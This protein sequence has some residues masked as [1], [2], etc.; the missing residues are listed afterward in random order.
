MST[1]LLLGVAGAAIGFFTGGVGFIGLGFLAGS[2]IGSLI[3]PQKVEGPRLGDLKLQVSTYGKM[4]PYV[5]GT[6]RIAGNVI[7]QTDLE[8]H[9]QKS[10]GKGGPE[11]ISYTYSASFDL[12]LCVGPILGIKRIWADARLIW[13]DD[14]G[15]PIPCTVYLGSASQTPDPTFE[16]IHGVGNV[17]GY[18]GF[19][20]VVFSDYF[21]TDFGNRIPQFEFEIF[22]NVG[23]FPWRVSEF[24]PQPDGAGARA[25]TYANGIVTVGVYKTASLPN[26]HYYERQFNLD[27]T[28]VAG[29]AFDAEVDLPGFP[30]GTVDGLLAATDGGGWYQREALVATI[31]VNPFGPA[32]V[33]T[34]VA[35]QTRVYNN[36]FIFATGS[37][38]LSGNVGLARWPCP[39]GVITAAT[40]TA[41]SF[42][43]LGTV[44]LSSWVVGKTNRS[45][46]CYVFDAGTITLFEYSFDLSTLIRQ[47]D[48]TAVNTTSPV[49]NGALFTVYQ[50][51]N[52]DLILA[53]DRGISGG[54]NAAAFYLNSD[55]TVS[56]IGN[57]TPGAGL[58][59]ADVSE[60]GNSGY[61]LVA[62]GIISL[63]PPTAP[64]P[65]STIVA[66]LSELTPLGGGGSPTN[67]DVSELIDDVRWFAVASQMGVRNAIAILRPLYFFDAVESD[68]IVKFR[69]RG[70]TPVFSIPDAS[71]CGRPYGEES[72][73]PLRTIREKEPGLPR[74]VTMTFYDVEADYQIGAKSSPRQVTLSQNDVTLDMPVGLTGAEAL[75][76][77]WAIQC[78]EWIERETFEWST[79]RG[80]HVLNLLTGT[81]IP[82]AMLEPCDVGIVRGREI[83][84]LTRN[85]TPAG[86]IT[87]TGVLSAPSIYTQT[88]PSSGGGFVPQLPP[89]ANV[90]TE[91]VL[92]DIPIL[93]QHDSPFGF[94]AAMGPA[95]TGRWPGATLYKSLDGGL[96]YTALVSSV[97]PSV[98]GHTQTSPGS[99]T[100][101]G[102]LASYGGGD[103]VD[104]SE[105]CLRLTDDDATLASI[106]ATALTNGANLCAIS[107]GYQGSPSTLK[108]ELLQFRDVTLVAANTYVLKGWLRGRKATLTS[109]H[110]TG[111]IFV[112]LPVTNVDAPESELNV[113]LKYKAVTS[114][115]AVADAAAQDFINTGLSALEYYETEIGHLPVFE[116]DTGSPGGG[117]P[118]IVPAPADGDCAAGKYLDACG[119]WSVP[120]GSG[121]GSPSP[122]TSPLTTK[123]DVWGYDTTDRRIPIGA[124]GTVLTAD[125]GQALGLKWAS[126]LTIISDFVGDAGSPGGGVHGLVPAP[127]SGDSL[128]DKYLH[129]SGDWRIVQRA[130]VDAPYY[131]AGPAAGC[132]QGRVLVPGSGITFTD[133]GGSPPI[134]TTIA[135]SSTLGKVIQVACSDQTTAITASTAKVTFRMP[136]AMT[137]TEVRASLKTGDVGSPTAATVV[138]INESGGSILST[139]LSIDAGETT[140]VTAAVPAVISDSAL[141]DDAEITIDVDSTGGSAVG[142]VVSIIG[143]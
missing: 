101:S 42:V 129:A 72:G 128:A 70:G 84:I 89:G 1:S 23:V 47:W 122:L 8:E 118:G 125:S 88:A 90:M 127:A 143:T 93:S 87:W 66:D 32:V 130:P 74:R 116:G 96:S 103:V 69:K 115:N 133:S 111:D 91:L 30:S 97:T 29:T 119:G 58:F 50:N 131:L 64:V 140:S 65:L 79:T 43:I 71:L 85:E 17:P 9:K 27:G 5:W 63:I 55:L 92:L 34:A 60:L 108:W 82:A 16:A 51:S 113:S 112:L 86:V 4:I 56:E 98:I 135:T 12:L 100:V 41:D 117:N 18:N 48:L 123:G 136:F 78:A 14:T 24:E 134:Q 25:Q 22:T 15:D 53:C 139:K 3:D 81:T 110:A 13:S 77:C 7:D 62:D 94:Y 132:S 46:V 36:G 37:G 28:E 45:D 26:G 121:G 126:P 142:L 80:G 61:A 38:T 68:D 67:Y 95:T 73:D 33:G 124:D 2:L 57:V 138:D 59:I 141:A 83:R 40:G 104:E 54:K 137:V 20:H 19:A 44:P 10:G 105:L 109:G 31:A 49:I 102:V 120:A 75:Q 11:V 35:G 76:K 106:T 107:T 52:G 114:G 99:P 39:N 6:G 21:L